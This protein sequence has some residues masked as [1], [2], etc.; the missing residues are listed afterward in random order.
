M[1]PLGSIPGE[2]IQAHARGFAPILGE[3][4]ANSPEQFSLFD[5]V[6]AFDTVL[7]VSGPAATDLDED[8]FQRTIRGG[9]LEN[10][11]DL[12]PFA[13]VIGRDQF[14]L[15]LPGKPNA[16]KFFNLKSVYKRNWASRIGM[17]G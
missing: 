15:K 14:G 7:P 2:N 5:P 1:I 3:V 8:Q 6:H 16:C 9:H 17:H 11:I 12:A 10:Q 13:S 4:V